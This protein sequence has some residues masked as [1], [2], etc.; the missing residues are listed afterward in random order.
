MSIIFLIILLGL[1]LLLTKLNH[2]SLSTSLV[3][4]IKTYVCVCVCV[5]HLPIYH[6]FVSNFLI[7]P[8][9]HT[10]TPT[11]THFPDLGTS[12]CLIQFTSLLTKDLP[13]LQLFY[14]LKALCSLY[15]QTIAVNFSFLEHSPHL[16]K[17]SL[18][19]LT[20]I[21][22]SLFPQQLWT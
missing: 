7:A 15:T 20:N 4:L 17:Y 10:H 14:L 11:H 19:S 6:C 21:L 3:M 8:N 9:L 18:F 12:T 5:L 16:S 1:H 2:Q 22:T 13:F